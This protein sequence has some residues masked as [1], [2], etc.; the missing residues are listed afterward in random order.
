MS[1]SPEDS[2]QEFLNI[3]HRSRVLLEVTLAEV[4]SFQPYPASRP[5]S[6]LFSSPPAMGGTAKEP[7]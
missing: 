7:F 2:A 3:A 6:Q 4:L 1:T 5:F